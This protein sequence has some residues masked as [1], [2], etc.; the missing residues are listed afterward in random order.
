MLFGAE[1]GRPAKRV[2]G[3]D[4]WLTL[5]ELSGLSTVTISGRFWSTYLAGCGRFIWPHLGVSR[6]DGG[7]AG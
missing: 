4:K 2:V 5:I 1:P 6:S 7:A 3:R